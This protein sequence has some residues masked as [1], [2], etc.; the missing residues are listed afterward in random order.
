MGGPLRRSRT[1]H[2]MPA[3][4]AIAVAAAIALAV[5]SQPVSAQ[6]GLPII[7]DS[8]IEQL[9]RDYTSP[10][11]RAAGLAQQNIQ[12]V[13]INSRAFNA[14]VMDGRRIFMNVGALYD[15]KVP[16]EVIGVLAHETG[17]ISGGH[18]SKMRD[19]MANAQTASIIAMLLG[20]GAIAAGAATGNGNVAQV[21]AA[22][23]QAPQEMI[24]RSL[25]SYIRAQEES[26]DRAAI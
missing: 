19:Q 2:A 26:A 23:V 22:A 12:V 3:S 18:L 21:G 6:G 4:R 9:M 15:A 11:L 8:E 16:N 25:L 7:R 20:V 14:F 5:T 10:I 17:H 13:L 1:R 24:R